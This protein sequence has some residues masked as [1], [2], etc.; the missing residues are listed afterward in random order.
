M[1]SNRTLSSC[2]HS[3]NCIS[4]LAGDA[5]HYVAPLQYTEGLHEARELLRSILRSMKRV[6]IVVEEPTYIHAEFTSALFRFVDDVEFLF[7]EPE[8]VI[9]VRSASRVGHY[10]FGANQKRIERIRNLLSGRHPMR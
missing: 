6:R 1:P 8:N 5:K 3:P 7:A 9:H 4:S 2:P 10:D